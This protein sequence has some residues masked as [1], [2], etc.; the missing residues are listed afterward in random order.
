MSHDYFPLAHLKTLTLDFQLLALIVLTCCVQA[1]GA[2]LAHLTDE[3]R[4]HTHVLWVNLQEELV[5]EGNG[6]IFAV[7]EPTCLDQHISIPSSDPELLEV[8]RK[9]FFFSV[10]LNVFHGFYIRLNK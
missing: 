5:L 1:T 9:F 10:F 2:V 7:R 8:E 3:K 4:K 6:Q